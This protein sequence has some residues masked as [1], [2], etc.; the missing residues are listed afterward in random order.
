MSDESHAARDAPVSIGRRVAPADQAIEDHAA[1][2]DCRSAALISRNGAVNWLCWPSFGAD[3]V[4]GAIL[5]T[6][7]GGFF[8]VTAEGATEVDR[9]YVEGTNVLETDYTT[10]TGRLRVT[11][12]L[13]LGADSLDGLEAEREL[14]RIVE[15]VDGT[16]T[17]RVTY[18]PRPGFARRL[19]KLRAS[20]RS[21]VHRTSRKLLSL[22][23]TAPLA[24]DAD[25]AVARGR[26]IM[27]RGEKQYLSLTH[28]A[29]DIGVLPPLGTHAERRCAATIR[30]W[31]SWSD[32][33]LRDLPFSD[34]V[35]RSALTLKMLA[36]ALSGAILAAPTTSLPESVGGQ[37]NWDYRFCWLRD[38]S[39]TLRVFID[40]GYEYEA[41]AFLDWLL[42]TTR[43]TQPRLDVLYDVY[44]RRPP[45]ERTLAHL[46]GYRA[47][48]P[49]RVGNAA[50]DQLQIDG[51]G[52]VCLAARYFVARGGRLDRVEKRLLAGFGRIV[53]KI[54]QAPDNGIWELRDDRRHHTY[55]KLMCWAAL[56]SLLEMDR[57]AG[58]PVRRSRLERTRES[59]RD[60]IQTQ[61]FD[62]D[63]NTFV[64]RPGVQWTDASLLAM[65]RTGFLAPDDP[66]MRG[67]F[68]TM[69]STLGAGPLLYRYPAGVDGFDDRE[70][71]FGLAGFW[72]A[73]YLARCGRVDEAAAR[74]EQ[75]LGF[76]ND[77]GL[78][79]EETD[80]VTG[81]HLG[82][83]PQAFTHVG[84]IGAAVSLG[85]AMK[86]Q[87]R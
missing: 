83:F 29:N 30:W 9:R 72:A 35:V 75:L 20:G 5:D 17:M 2:G 60:W 41:Q 40:L 47:S 39:L 84:F 31:K 42:H 85:K 3:A 44:G 32:R 74:I 34:A 26:F 14:L 51:Y 33:C 27:H 21:V 18:A 25:G 70:G 15:C 82:N 61:A 24:L 38:A 28:T 55:S 10:P 78:F 63:R 1:I 36:Y 69:E 16:A 50:A 81:A 68:E 6:T 48:R 71:A 62:A 86:A 11:D 46:A 87:R 37:R 59:I 58:L 8:E 73:D 13:T 23:T 64:S 57:L 53:T 80:P 12:S 79:S 67:T 77:V 66:R 49:V 43:L 65:A 54:W 19:P 56:D 4:F 52:A 45:P 22:Q 7:S 76:A